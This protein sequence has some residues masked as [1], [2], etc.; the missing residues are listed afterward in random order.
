MTEKDVDGLRAENARLRELAERDW[1]TGLYNRGSTEQRVGQA[2]ESWKGGAM[3]VLDIDWFKQ[4]NDQYGHLMGDEILRDVA[5]T[6]ECLFFQRDIVGRVGGDE[7]AV[8]VTADCTAQCIEG[9]V[10]RVR[11]LL[12]EAGLRRG[13]EDG[14]SVSVGVAYRKEEDGYESLFA[15]ADRAL[16]GA[17]KRRR[18]ARAEA[19]SRG[20]CTDM[21][22][23]Q[24]ELREETVLPGAYC[25]DYE[26]FKRIYRFVER[27]LRRSGSSAYTILLTLSDGQGDFVPLVSR[28]QLLNRLQELVQTSLRSG[29]VFTR[30]SSCQYLLMVL[31]ASEENAV[32]IGQRV[33]ARFQEEAEG[34][35]DVQIEYHVYPMHAASAAVGK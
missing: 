2:M 8:Y 1:L 32:H 20:I 17:K 31:G 22:L 29:D 16:L 3:L 10:A 9:K 27:G 24:R 5:R 13:I 4:V 35:I 30:Y 21:S 19:V 6:L 33:C 26:T 18:T 28:T 23:I 12:E 34:Q 15:R 7:F 14:I 11:A 25:Q